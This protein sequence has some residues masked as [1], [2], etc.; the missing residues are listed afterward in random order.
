MRR[1]PVLLLSTMLIGLAPS[2]GSAP[3]QPITA[4][5]PIEILAAGFHDLAGIAVDTDGAV[6]VADHDAG[7]VIRI[8]ADHVPTRIAA[9]LDRPAGLAFDPTGRLLVVEEEGGRVVRIEPGGGITRVVQGLERPRWLAVSDDG[10]LFV[11][12]RAGDDRDGDA[13]HEMVIAVSPGGEAS[14][15]MAGLRHLG[16]VAVEP[17]ALY[18]AVG[19]LEPGGEDGGV[20]RIA[21]RPDGTAGQ[22][23]VVFSGTRLKHPLGLARDRLGALFLTADKVGRSRDKAQQAVVKLHPDAQ[24]SV[25]ARDLGDPQALAFDGDGNLLVADGR[26]GRVVRF[27]A[28]PGPTLNI[29]EFISQLPFPLAGTT[30]GGA[31]VDVFLN[32]ATTPVSVSATTTGAFSLG[33]ALAANATNSLEAFTTTHGGAGLTSPPAEATITHDDLAP[34][35]VFLAPPAGAHV[36]Q[37]LTVQAQAADGGSQIASLGLTVDGQT[38]TPVLAPAPPAATVA[39]A[40]TWGTLA[41][42]DGAHTLAATAEDR[43]G[44]RAS[45]SRIVLVDNTPPDTQITGGPQTDIRETTATFT[46]TGSDNLTPAAD[47]QFA[48]RLD[49]RPWSAFDSATTATLTALAPGPHRFE[50]KTRDLAGNEDASAA[51][52]SFTVSRLRVTITAPADGSTVAVGMLLIRGTVEAG[53]VEVGVAVN[54]VPVAVPG[55]VFAVLVP[56]TNDMTTITALATATDGATASRTI[57]LVVTAPVGTPA[58]LQASPASGTAPLTVRFSLLGGPVPA[59]VELDADG[60]GVA[61]LVAP[62]L[63]GQT[64]TYSRPGLYVPA[65]TIT[66]AQGARITTRAV[67]QVHDR[68]GLDGALQARWAAMRDALRAGDIPG[69]LS[70]LAQRS[71]PRYERIFQVLAPR[72]A[73]VDSMLTAL[74]LDEVGEREVYYVMV[75]T[76][77]GVTKSFE[78]RFVLDED[79]L[80]RLQRF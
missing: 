23:S 31:R 9:G 24:A 20:V 5:A 62:S 41:I 36:R 16:G 8:G 39:A 14:V 45:V 13:K 25:L 64:F 65:V 76:D 29:R 17:S 80:W 46:F 61:D 75:R 70:H 50:V 21:I 40:A 79:G 78:V 73:A 4:L 37:T 43:A 69:A 38:L 63:D 33:L 55:T 51:E 66:D 2:T 42:P 32:D 52:R 53:G 26:R 57:S 18:V 58:V 72:L 11:T 1:V 44:N 22:L 54:G 71:R 56:V 12:T 60:D 34:A 35:L 3:P 27:R 68:T 59:L 49:D 67:V 19:D 48:W 74:V 7:T 15:F 6:Y 30:E 77:A 28:P 47:L 10:R